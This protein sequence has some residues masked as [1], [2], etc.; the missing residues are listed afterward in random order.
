MAWHKGASRCFRKNGK[1]H[2]CPKP[3]GWAGNPE[4]F[5][6]SESSN[7]S[8]A[9]QS[10]TPKSSKQPKSHGHWTKK[11]E[12][13]LEESTA[14]GPA[15]ALGVEW[16]APFGRLVTRVLIEADQGKFGDSDWFLFFFYVFILF[17]HVMHDYILP[18]LPSKCKHERRLEV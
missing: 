13:L 16:E 9:F 10:R 12:R 18:P 5:S 11:Q 17:L 7:F 15:A 1:N 14:D 3:R 4:S 6:S 8:W 2:S